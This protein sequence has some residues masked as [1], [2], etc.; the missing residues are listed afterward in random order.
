M[1]VLTVVWFD[2]WSLVVTVISVITV[3]WALVPEL[4]GNGNSGH[5]NN[6]ECLSHLCREILL[7]FV[8][9][10]LINYNKLIYLYIASTT[11]PS[12]PLLY[13]FSN[14]K[15]YL[16]SLWGFGVLGFWGFGVVK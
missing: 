8:R 14:L 11:A 15:S 12:S 3:V 5:C 2:S 7:I 10:D 1:D 9:V 13:Y 4:L 16:L 6:N